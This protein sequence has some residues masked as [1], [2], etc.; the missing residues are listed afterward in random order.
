MVLS[1]EAIVENNGPIADL[2]SAAVFSQCLE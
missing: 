1:W 2:A